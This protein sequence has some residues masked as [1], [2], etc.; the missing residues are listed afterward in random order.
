MEFA[1]SR[2][3]GVRII[4]PALHRISEFVA[5]D[6]G[7]NEERDDEGNDGL[8]L[9]A[10]VTVFE[11]NATGGL[12]LH[13]S[14]NVIK[15]GWDETESQRNDHRKDVGWESDELERVEIPFKR[16]GQIQRLGRRGENHGKNDHEEE[17]KE[18]PRSLKDRVPIDDETIDIESRIIL[19]PWN[20]DVDDQDE[21]DHYP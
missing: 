11:I 2:S 18:N 3:L 8:D 10:K 5:S 14:L 21:D 12:G 6:E 15:D 4:S 20:K 1:V 13:D 16:G 9:R 19:G 17:T 7:G